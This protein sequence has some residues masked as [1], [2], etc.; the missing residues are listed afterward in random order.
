[1]LPEV[2]EIGLACFPL[3]VGVAPAP[4][5]DD[6]QLPVGVEVAR[7]V[8]LSLLNYSKYSK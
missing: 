8:H 1:M 4:A 5:E 2:F 3:L 6:V 7:G